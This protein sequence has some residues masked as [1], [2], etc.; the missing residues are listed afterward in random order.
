MTPRR[1]NDGTDW[2]FSLF[3]NIGGG[4]GLFTL[5]LVPKVMTFVFLAFIVNLFSPSTKSIQISLQLP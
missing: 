5:S 2:N 3:I 4:G 1:L